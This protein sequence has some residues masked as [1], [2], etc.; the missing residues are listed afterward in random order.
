MAY[1]DFFD[2]LYFHGSKSLK[3]KWAHL[4]QRENELQAELGQH[5]AQIN[6]KL[7]T[8]QGRISKVQ[9]N[10]LYGIESSATKNRGNC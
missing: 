8:E 7:A 9:Q 5:Q 4:H 3:K 2:I 6:P 1:L 10:A